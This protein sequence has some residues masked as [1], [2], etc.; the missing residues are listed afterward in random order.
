[1]LTVENAG[2]KGSRGVA[3]MCALVPGGGVHAQRVPIFALNFIFS[4]FS[5]ENSI[6]RAYVI[7]PIT[8]LHPPCLHL[9]IQCKKTLRFKKLI[10]LIT[11]LNNYYN[12]RFRVFP[13]TP[14]PTLRWS[15]RSRPRG[16]ATRRTTTT[17]RRTRV[18]VSRVTGR[19]RK[20]RW[21]TATPA[22]AT[23]SAVSTLWLPSFASR[24]CEVEDKVRG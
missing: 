11:N 7:P 19:P 21:S 10:F 23:A 8:N 5:Y 18:E 22:S 13:E 4:K 20:T 24:F 16:P 17:R 15:A 3:Q 9:C 12:F 14:A 2:G 1:M 6:G